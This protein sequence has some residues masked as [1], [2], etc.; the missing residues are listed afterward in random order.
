MAYYVFDDNKCK[1]ETLTKEQIIAAIARATGNQPASIDDAFIS[2]IKEKNSGANFT[3]WVGTTAEYSALATTER[4]CLYILTDDTFGDDIQT[5]VE[6][7]RSDVAAMTESFS[8]IEAD[9]AELR[10]DVDSRMGTNK[11]VLLATGTIAADGSVVNLDSSGH[12]L[13]EFTKLLILGKDTTAP[14]CI[15]IGTLGI[16]CDVNSYGATETCHVINYTVIDNVGMIKDS[17]AVLSSWENKVYFAK[18]YTTGSASLGG[19]YKI[20]GVK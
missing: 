8:A 3:F 13:S 12:S 20:Y 4:N 17:A 6:D 18:G 19:T 15:G 5:T 10:S 11:P 14:Y 2:K 1:H 9:F 7:I 16:D